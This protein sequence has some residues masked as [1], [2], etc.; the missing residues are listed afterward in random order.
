MKKYVWF[1]DTHLNH[2]VLPFLK[3]RFVSRLRE[4]A[5]DGLF[6]TGDISSGHW[7]E[8]DLR[9]LARNFDGPIYFVLGNHDY[10]F[11]HIE[12]VHADVRR[13]CATHLNLH[14][15]TD[16]GV[17]SLTEDVALIGTEGWYDAALGDPN[18]LR[19]TPDWWM[20]FD[21]LHH[22]DMSGRLNKFRDMAK[23]S[24]DFIARKLETA[25]ETHKTVYVLT[26]VPPWKEATRA[27]GTRMER[28]WLPYNTNAAMGKEIERVMDGREEKHAIVFAGHTHTPC[29]I[30]VSKSIEC[31][32]ARA[33]YWG[34][35]RAEETIIIG[36]D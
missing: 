23:A 17:I 34:K 8:S 30:Q 12:S 19:Y 24:A 36:R 27:E 7:L 33:S 1:S 26:H 32:V 22:D 20:T 6:L 28:Y 5:P 31:N 14:W 3:R 13:L 9:F 21:F 10:H 18:L 16:S 29:T 2:S 11:R 4:A 25:L 35:V 15:M